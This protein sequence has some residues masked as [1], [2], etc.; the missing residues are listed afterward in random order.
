MSRFAAVAA[1]IV[2]GAL[3]GCLYL[4]VMLGRPGALI[5]VYLTQ[6]PLFMAGLWLGAVNAAL[7]QGVLARFS[8]N[9]RP[10]PR[11]VE[12]GLPIWLP[13]AL[14]LALAATFFGG[15]WSFIGVNTMIALSV[16][17]CLAGLAVLHAA[18]ARLSHPAM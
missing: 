16:P 4:A 3:A 13:A 11:L 15:P 10:S 1:A 9:W 8:A 7:A 12:L 14:G 2:C 6:L 18:A 5:L 17:F